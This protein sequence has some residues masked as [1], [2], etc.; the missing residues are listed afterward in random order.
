VSFTP[1]TASRVGGALGGAIAKLS[2]KVD[3]NREL[4]RND[5][6][7][8][9]AHRDRAIGTFDK[10]TRPYLKY[11]DRQ[12]PSTDHSPLLAMRD[13][14]AFEKGQEVPD[15]NTRPFFAHMR[16]MLDT[17]ATQIRS[18][19]KGFLEHLVTDYFP[20]QWKD[21]EAAAMFY[22]AA[23]QRRPL[24]GRKE[25]SRERVFDTLEDG[26]KAGLTP[27]THNPAEMVLQ[28]YASGERL[29][30]QLRIMADLEKRGLVK[31]VGIGER[32]P[33]GYAH[34]N[35]PAFGNRVVPELIARDL[36]NYLDPGL[37]KYAPWRGFRWL[38]NMMLSANLGFSAFHAGMTTIDTI[39]THADIGWR[40]VALLGDLKGGLRELANIP[41]AVVKS[42]Y[43]GGKLVKQFYG[44]ASSDPHTA[45]ILHMLT[46]GGAR[47]YMHPSDINDSF[48]KMLRAYDQG[49]KV[50]LIKNTLPGLI[51]GS[52]RLISHKLVPA[53]KMVARIMH[54]KFRLD[55]VAG[56]LGKERGDYAGI[57]DA[58]N[59]D[60]MRAM[61]HE[62]NSTI[63]DRLGQ[64]AYDN[65]FWNKTFRDF[66]H[67]SVQ[68]V[69][70]NFGTL[71][72]LL[73][74]AKDAKALVAP[75]H[76]TMP[77]DKAGKLTDFKKSR[78]SDR[79]S[80]LLTLNAVVGLSG[81]M[82]QYAM[83][84]QGPQELKDFFFPRTGR[85]NRD[86]SDERLSFPSYV[87]DEFALATHPITT[88]SHKVHP[89]FSKMIELANNRDFY[90]VQIFDPEASIPQEAKEILT[91]LGKSFMP[92]AVT[93]AMKA[94][95]TGA[96]AAMTALP[97][98]G[99]TPAPGDITRTPFLQ[100]VLE[101][102]ADQMPR[103]KTLSQAE[104][105]VLTASRAQALRE[106][107]LDPQSL[108]PADAKRVK[109]VMRT[110]LTQYRF[111][112]LP[113]PQQV[114]AYEMATPAERTE[115]G[116]GGYINHNLG[117]KL[118]RLPPAARSD[119]VQKIR[120]FSAPG[121]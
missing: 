116:L 71:R 97:F 20:H 40:R 22:G 49:D 94:N 62:I 86:G 58:M 96:S 46:E 47:G 73:G 31:Q 27:A 15:P 2:P 91:Y 115:F 13:A 87:K 107:K 23:I 70:W 21:P 63:D 51:E 108:S 66:L 109:N 7:S 10:A 26:I 35:D 57:V 118:S 85:K 8:A 113:L 34:V 36:N 75:E 38:Q 42:P 39:A 5:I 76:Y 93:G 82:L 64:F 43:E 18:Y 83:T 84:G 95:A 30:S 24:G 65:L 104:Q 48:T 105:S 102:Y 14:I 50:G 61:S 68:S 12:L 89:I 44:Q 3:P 99:I 60:A 25:F 32:V 29:L 6:R 53:Q 80:Y 55:E 98:V 81:A 67:A 4:V 112:R 56:A 69:G 121:Q 11:Y 114:H 92:Y 120:E 37:T 17:Q 119:V 45:A 59:I 54:A 79:L 41:I 52:S 72:L 9:L 88:A 106:G 77:L 28:R 103:T 78:L 90:G 1:K 19:G 111:S 117:A 110:S 74:G 33:R 101:R 100:Y 16:K